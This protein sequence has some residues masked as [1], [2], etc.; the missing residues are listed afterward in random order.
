MNITY[1]IILSAFLAVSA[2]AAPGP[3]EGTWVTAC[4]PEQGQF[5]QSSV[6]ASDNNLKQAGYSY[7]D[8]A[9]T[10]KGIEVVINSTAQYG[11]SSLVV[12]GANEIDTI[13]STI[14][15]TAHDP[16]YIPYFNQTQLCGYSDWALGMTKDVTGKTCGQTKLP[17]SGSA[18]YDIWA[19]QSG[20]LIAG[21][22]SKQY[23][24]TTKE[25]RIR[26]LDTQNPMTKK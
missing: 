8:A 14:T 24:G 12:P 4:K 5:S 2:I 6:T 13:I 3:F 1:G 11:S 16:R 20:K 26:E 25:L 22:P 15:L 19:L 18:Y 9:C 10:Q 7:F 23:P 17:A 21:K